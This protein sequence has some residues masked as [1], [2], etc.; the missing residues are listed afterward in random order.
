MSLVRPSWACCHT[1]GAVALVGSNQRGARLSIDALEAVPQAEVGVGDEAEDG[2]GDDVPAAVLCVVHQL[3]GGLELEGGKNSAAC[4]IA[5]MPAWP[6]AA[7][8]QPNWPAR[9][10]V[11]VP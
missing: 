4:S 7:C 2:G 10:F 9:F 11:R 8:V 6:A 3:A 5:P 1:T